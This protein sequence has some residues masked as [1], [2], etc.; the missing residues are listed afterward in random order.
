MTSR[1]QNLN[2]LPYPISL[3][4]QVKMK[5]WSS[6][7]T[8]WF[9]TSEVPGHAGKLVFGLLADH[10]PVVLMVGRAQWELIIHSSGHFHYW[11]LL[12]F[13]LAC[14]YYEGH[15]IHQVT[16]PIRVFKLLGIETIVCENPT[17]SPARDIFSNHA[18]LNSNKRR[19]RPQYRICG[20]R[21]RD[22]QRCM[23][24]NHVRMLQARHTDTVE[25]CSTS[26]LQ[27]SQELIPCEGQTRRNSDPDSLLCLM[28][29]ISSSVAC[30]SGMESSDKREQYTKTARGCVCLCCGSQVRDY[31]S[32]TMNSYATIH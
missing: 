32:R 5:P 7:S 8:C 12:M 26:S 20:W 3:V 14:S 11:R 13:Y 9:L 31:F 30:T 25:N 6:I 4:W 22:H 29:T 19:R 16:F 21:H 17:L 2:I 24:D 18:W 27:D 28:H 1:E 15:S 23:S 10:I